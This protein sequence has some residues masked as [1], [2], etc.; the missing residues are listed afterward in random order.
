MDNVIIM[1]NFQTSSFIKTLM[2]LLSQEEANA[3]KSFSYITIDTNLLHKSLGDIFF[4]STI[5][6]NIR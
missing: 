4:N 3:V 1:N 2:T 5:T 6:L